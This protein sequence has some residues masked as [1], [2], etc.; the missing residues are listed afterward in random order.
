[1]KIINEKGKLFGI[2]NVIDLLV[3]LLVCVLAF[4]GF[5]FVR[6]GGFAS[7]SKADDKNA[8]FDGPESTIIIKYYQ[9]EVS[10]FVIDKLKVG[11]PAYDDYSEWEVGKVVDFEVGP[12]HSYTVNAQGENVVTEKEGYSSLIVTTEVTGK[13]T[14]MGATVDKYHYTVGHTLVLRA[15]EAKLYPRIY[16]IQLKERRIRR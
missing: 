7:L 12:A 8:I 5:V 9:E 10:D 4:A 6:N 3:L 14:P 15:G 16:D 13:K 11:T 2:I 1:M